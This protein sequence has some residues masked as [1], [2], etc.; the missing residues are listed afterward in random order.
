MCWIWSSHS[1]GYEEFCTFWDIT[2][3]SPVKVSRRFGGTYR[4]HSQGRRA[5]QPEARIKLCSMPVSCWFLTWLILRPWRWRR[6]VPLKCR[7]IFTGLRGVM[8]QKI[9]LF[10]LLIFVRTFKTYF[11]HFPYLLGRTQQPTHVLVRD[12]RKIKV[13]EWKNHWTYSFTF[14]PTLLFFYFFH[15]CRTVNDIVYI[16]YYIIY[17]EQYVV[18]LPVMCW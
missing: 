2:P 3:Y 7:S 16:L 14:L 6:F 1:G 10:E 15:R 8:S 5:S 4:H 9:E 18:V 13:N 17:K 11:C 12:G